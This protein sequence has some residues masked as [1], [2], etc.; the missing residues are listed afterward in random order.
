M[1]IADD[2]ATLDELVKEKQ[3]EL[4][5]HRKAR[6]KF[7]DD[8]RKCQMRRNALRDNARATIDKISKLKAE[9]AHYNELT[10]EAKANREAVKERIDEARA[11]GVRDLDGLK[12]ERDEYHQQVVEYHA[13]AQAAHEEIE[14]LREQIDVY[15]KLADE[16]HEQSIRFKEA[17]DTEHQEFVRCMNELRELQDELP[18]TL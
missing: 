9:R 17:A 12:R 1:S 6:D 2:I 16:Q 10:R 3:A 18:D 13:K 4:N 8:M 5:N 11:S 7:Q 15:R 14:K